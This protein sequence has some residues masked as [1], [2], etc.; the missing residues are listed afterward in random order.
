MNSKILFVGTIMLCITVISSGIVILL[1]IYTPSYNHASLDTPFS[2]KIGE[3]ITLDDPGIVIHF[4]DVLE[5]SR[6]PTDVECIWEGNVS[7]ALQISYQGSFLGE[8][9]LDSSNLH[10]AAFMDYYVKLKIL[11]PYPVSTETIQKA[12]YNGT[13]VLGQYGLD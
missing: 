4:T 5:D 3:Y 1:T 11:E 2:L 7:L 13:F 10:K 9:T 6:C 12:D 8:Y